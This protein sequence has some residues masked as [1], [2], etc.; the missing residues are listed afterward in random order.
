[1]VD[2]YYEEELRYLYESGREFATAHPDRAR[3]LN[4]DAVGDR[5]PYVE[6]L[7]EGFA[8]LTARIREK[9]DDGLPELTE[10]LINL[11][12]PQFLREVPSA[13]VV[14]FA[15]RPG[16][17]TESRVLPRGTEVLSGPVGRESVACRFIT[18][19]KVTI[20]P[21]ALKDV[22]KSVDRRGCATVALTFGIDPRASWEH[23]LLAPLR[24]YLHAERPLALMLRQ[25]LTSRV[26]QASVAADGAAVPY[27]PSRACMPAGYAGDESLLPAD[28]RVTHASALLLEYFAYPEKFLF[29][30]LFG[31]DALPRR[32]QAPETLTYTLTFDNDFD[33]DA[34][35][36]PENLRLFCSP[37]VNLFKTDIEPVNHAGRKDEY[38][39]TADARHPESTTVHSVVSVTGID[40]ISGGRRAYKPLN[41]FAGLGKNGDRT[42]TTRHG[43]SADGRRRVYLVPGG[44]GLDGL[45]LREENLAVE[46]W[47]TNGVLP[48]EE[49]NEGG[50]N[51]GGR[52]FPDS[53]MVS[54]ITRPTLPCYPPDRDDYQWVFLAH[55]GANY[56]S[57][58]SADSLQA[59]LR[60]YDWSR[61]PAV[62][63]RIAAITDVRA[64]PSE[65]I[66][67]GSLIRGVRFEVSVIASQFSGNADIR[68][69]GEVLREFLAQY[70]SINTYLDLAMVLKPDGETMTFSSQPGAQWLI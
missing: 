30:D 46:A 41:T 11:M 48:R 28:E 22:K 31:A 62:A 27:D 32:G 55:Q 39:L 13:A 45:E 52:A 64:E 49:I 9:L 37:V 18:T 23:L 63:R 67:A 58:A 65:R 40:R 2:K 6:R 54:N 68:M 15:P 53:V 33:N 61:D 38:M 69:L 21:I 56:V 8:F 70:V 16:L 3:F 43:R 10:G 50:I 47:C 51:R 66:V 17:L 24:L 20:N 36:G 59:F 35:I 42:F 14:Q 26:R 34:R 5:D 12:W 1:M 57:L 19:H 44:E 25:F 29:V 4:I 60:L 7:F